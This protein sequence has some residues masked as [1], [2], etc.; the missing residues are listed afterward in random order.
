VKKIAFVVQRY[1]QEV[2]G[3]SELFASLWAEKLSQYYSVEV[4]TTCALDY[5]TWENHYPEGVSNINNINVRRFTVEKTRDAQKL[6]DLTELIADKADI[7]TEKEWVNEQGPYCPE[8]IEYIKTEK[9]QFDVFIFMTYL[10]YTTVYGIGEV[11]EKAILV[12]TAHDEYPIYYSVYKE[13][14]S[15]PRA[16]VFNTEEERVFV[17]NL[18]GNRSI[19]GDIIGI[20]IDILDNAEPVMFKHKFG[21]NNYILYAGRVD[22]TK[23]CPELF[24]YFIEYKKRNT[25]DLKLV[26]MGKEFVEVPKHHDIVSLGFI[27]DDDKNNGMAGAKLIVMPSVF[28][29]LSMVVLESMASGVPVVVNAKSDV[30]KGHCLK[31]NAGLY[32]DGYYEFE[33]CINYLLDNEDVYSAMSKNA[34][35]YVK[36]NYCW[37]VVID[38]FRRLIERA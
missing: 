33:G 5:I 13:I 35:K 16:L 30:V 27:S 14:L 23:N 36:G 6:A 17:Q 8:L 37:D 11:R 15:C 19:S 31:S 21:L 24:K 32:Y 4:L 26:L 25:S 1:G 28:E 22:N 7:G 29:S 34:K 10:Y 2:T 18:L 38:K 20:G 12:P 9:D 3:G